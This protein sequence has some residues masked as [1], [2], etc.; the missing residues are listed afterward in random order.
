M[1]KVQASP[2][3][4]LEPIIHGIYSHFCQN[5]MMKRQKFRCRSRGLVRAAMR[6]WL[7]GLWNWHLLD[8]A[9]ALAVANASTLASARRENCPSFVGFA[10]RALMKASIPSWVSERQL[11]LSTLD[12]LLRRGGVARSSP[13][14]ANHS[15]SLN[16]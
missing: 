10:A 6:A 2:Y 15:N 9:P 12:G 3:R 16:T 1:Q 7:H 5:R 4:E 13:I 14:G 11:W 8:K